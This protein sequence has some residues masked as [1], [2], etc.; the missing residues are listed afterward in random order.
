MSMKRKTDIST[1]QKLEDFCGELVGQL[2]P[3]QLLLLNGPMAVGKTTF[4]YHLVK[5]MGGV[6]ASS[7]T[8][9]IHQIYASKNTKIDHIDLYRLK[10]DADLESTG[11]WDLFDKKSGLII[12][13]WASRLEGQWWP[14]SWSALNLEFSFENQKRIITITS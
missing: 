7:P 9:A 8:Y 5:A 12:V 6:S 4:V 1:S 13:E 14:N 3:R 11:F 10:N 2:M